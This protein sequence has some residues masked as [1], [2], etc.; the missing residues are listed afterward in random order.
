MS[1][2]RKALVVFV[3]SLGALASA[4]AAEAPFG[5]AAEFALIMDFETGE[6]LFEK[7]AQTPTAPASMSKLMT[8]AVVFEK[9]KSGEL[10]LEDEFDVSKKAWR[11]KGSKMWVRVDTRIRLEDLL[12]GVIIQSGNDAC[13][14]IAE[15]I[16]GSEDAFADLMNAKAR[17]WGL[18]GSS[19]ANASGWPH[20]DQKMSMRDLG[21]L[22]RKI[23]RDYPEY[24][25]LFS[26]AE[27]TWE[28]IR[29]ANR[30]P[31]LGIVDGAD[32]LKTGHTEES[33]YGVVGSAVKGDARRIVVLNGLSSSRERALESRRMLTIAFNDF[34]KKDFFAAGD[35]VGEAVVFGGKAKTVPLILRDPVALLLHRSELDGV[36]TT[37]TYEGPVAAP[38]EAGGQIGLL[39]A[40]RPGG[41]TRDY[42][43]YAGRSVSEQGPLGK[44]KQAAVKLLTK[45]DRSASAPTAEEDGEAASAPSAGAE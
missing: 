7:N 6:T 34:A 11:M 42:P 20:P 29:Q 16:S 41:E 10:S 5:T 17:D 27:F 23:I 38:I 31:L 25:D 35:I 39:R 22:A 12:R 33:G 32:G 9:L 14:V 4:R 24:Y 3:V 8:V 45:P 44:I 37:L 30:N 40:T 21:M 1:V 43:L 15:N 26:E 13:I 19:F 36:T 2:I 18:T 28:K